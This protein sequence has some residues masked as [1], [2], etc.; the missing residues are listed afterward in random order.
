N[1]AMTSV[2]LFP[3]WVWT[4]ELPVDRAAQTEALG[5]TTHH[6]PPATSAG[7]RQ[8]I[9]HPPPPAARSRNVDAE[10][11]NSVRAQPDLGVPVGEG[12]GRVVLPDP[13]VEFP[14]GKHRMLG[15]LLTEQHRRGIRIPRVQR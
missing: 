14:D 2:M 12:A 11:R 5:P 3:P 6:L 10:D 7:G 1:R 9:E 13:G 15:E 8:E 4:E